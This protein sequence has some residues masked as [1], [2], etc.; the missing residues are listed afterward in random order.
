MTMLKLISV[1]KIWSYAK[2]NALTDLIRFHHSWYCVF[3]ESTKHVYGENGKIRLIKSN[4]GKNWDSIA[5]FE[6]P[7]IDLRDPKLSITPNGFLMLLVSGTEYSQK[8]YLTRQSQVSFSQDGFNWSSF[9]PI[10]EPHEWLWRVTWYEGKAYGASYRFSNP[11]DPKQ[12]WLIKLFKS[13][14]G[15]HYELVTNWNIP[16]RPNETTLRFFSDGMMVALVRREQLDHHDAWIG[17]SSPPYKQWEWHSLGCYFGGPNFLIF[18]D[19]TLWAAGRII[20]T[21]PYG[22][23][24]KTIVAKI[25]DY[26][27]S[28]LLILP[29]GGDCSYPGMMYDEGCLWIS[30]YSS[31]EGNSAIYLAQIQ[32]LE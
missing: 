30:Y 23:F 32:L 21:N 17:N 16:G 24:E 8:H 31:H 6:Q 28:S 7:G 19:Q 15:V 5:L 12:E 9:R 18:S 2:H 25:A 26:S 29:S 20:W 1:K 22:A 10:L 4:D 13:S 27:L 3:R 11:Q 14:D